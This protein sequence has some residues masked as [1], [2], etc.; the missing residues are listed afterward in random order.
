M[1]KDA[2][3]REWSTAITV[4]TVKRVKELAGVLLT[5]VDVIERISSDVM[6]LCDV[7]SA[8]SKSQRDE[9]NVSSEQFGELLAGKF[10]DQAYDSFRQD[11]LDFFP[12]SRRSVM[13]R[14]FS[15][16]QKLETERLR[17]V[18]TKLTDEQVEILVRK[19]IQRASDQIDRQLE[20]LGNAS[21]NSPESSESTQET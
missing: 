12:N 21:G 2:N 5:D 4:T 11:L 8:I 9:R 17:L 19:T 6:L 3:G 14:I 7:L 15:T 20:Q 10:I 1:W 16:T 13:Q 18:E